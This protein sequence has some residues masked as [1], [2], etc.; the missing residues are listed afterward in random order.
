MKPV[1][2][3]PSSV[4]GAGRRADA[5]SVSRRLAVQRHRLASMTRLRGLW[6]SRPLSS[7]PEIAAG[8]DIEERHDRVMKTATDG[9]RGY[10]RAKLLLGLLFDDDVALSSFNH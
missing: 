5:T 4:S 2:E 8:Q 10:R 6:P 1:R 3:R 7:S 9:A